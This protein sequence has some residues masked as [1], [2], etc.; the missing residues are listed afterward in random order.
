MFQ[1]LFGWAAALEQ[2]SFLFFKRGGNLIAQEIPPGHSVH[3]HTAIQRNLQEML[4][5]PI[6]A[7]GLFIVLRH[8]NEGLTVQ[9]FCLRCP[10]KGEGDELRCWNI[11]AIHLCDLNEFVRSCHLCGSLCVLFVL[12][13]VALFNFYLAGRPAAVA[14]IQKKCLGFFLLFIGCRRPAAGRSNLCRQS[15]IIHI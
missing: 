2:K 5:T 9:S 13:A 8:S 7:T 4:A 12:V 1:F 11:G 10:L 6:T 14:L 3:I 15:R